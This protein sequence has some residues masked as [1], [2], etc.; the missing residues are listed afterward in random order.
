MSAQQVAAEDGAQREAG[1]DDRTLRDVVGVARAERSD[2]GE[3][4]LVGLAEG[5]PRPAVFTFGRVVPRDS[6]WTQNEGERI[7]D[8]TPHFA[9]PFRTVVVT[10]QCNDDRSLVARES[11]QRHGCVAESLHGERHDGLRGWKRGRTSM[12]ADGAGGGFAGCE[13]E[14]TGARDGDDDGSRGALAESWRPRQPK[15]NATTP[16]ARAARIR[17][18]HSVSETPRRS[19]ARTTACARR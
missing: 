17:A 8:S 14:G 1:E 5:A 7:G 12:L 15:T 4:L 18:E 9:L 19:G 6:A 3:E 13:D 2:G 16:N 11:R 10:V